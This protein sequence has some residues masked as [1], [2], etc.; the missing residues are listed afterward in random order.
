MAVDHAY[1]QRK[2]SLL[3][4]SSSAAA[5]ERDREQLIS[6]SRGRKC[7]G[8]SGVGSRHGHVWRPG[9]LETMAKGQP[10]MRE[11][12][13]RDSVDGM[14]AGIRVG[15]MCGEFSGFCVWEFVER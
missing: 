11:V 9:A 12:F 15:G 13:E 10:A 2:S 14:W 3:R 8:A 1:E 7:I 5:H 6:S 4:C